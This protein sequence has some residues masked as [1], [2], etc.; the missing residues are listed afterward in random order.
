MNK[1]ILVT[2]ACGFIGSYIV[3]KELKAGNKVFGTKHSPTIGNEI[4]SYDHILN[5]VDITRI[6][7]VEKLVERVKPDLVY[8]LAA[9]SYPAVSWEKPHETFRVN[10]DGTFNLLESLRRHSPAARV[11]LACS[12]AQYGDV[13]P[14]DA[15]VL[16]T[17]DLK[18]L[19]PYGVSKAA[20]EMLGY[21]FHSNYGLDCINARIFNTTGPRKHGDV[22]ADFCSRLVEIERSKEGTLRV[23]NLDTERALLDVR[24]TADALHKLVRF[25]ESGESYNIS[26]DHAIKIGLIVE[27]LKANA[28]CEF[29]VSVDSSLI[30]AADEVIIWGDSSKLKSAVKWVPEFKI[31]DTIISMIN[32]FRA[33]VS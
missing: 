12:S 27:I 14:E 28:L 31:E 4:S 9:Q 22:C 2:G 7:Q 24:D 11:V 10:I 13:K 33:R 15:P 23:G 17:H 20:T 6:D 1:N 32:Y 8:H 19:H 18:P 30:R 26:A 25:G 3:A 29:Q 5:F 21:Q 16:E